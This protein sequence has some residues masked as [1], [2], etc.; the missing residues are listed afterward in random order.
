M[1]KLCK[2]LKNI[3]VAFIA[4]IL[5]GSVSVCIYHNYQLSKESA[6]IK[7]K[8]TLV[9]FNNKKINVYNEGSGEDTYVFMS[10]SGIAAP[11]YEM[12]GV[13][14]SFLRNLSIKK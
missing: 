12:K 2:V 1:R 6:L 7:S 5:L 13:Y 9:D 10:G 4:V 11:V 8:R 14:I 3:F